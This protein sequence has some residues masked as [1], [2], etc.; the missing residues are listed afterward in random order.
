M[1]NT[2]TPVYLAQSQKMGHRTF[3]RNM[4]N[5]V[6]FFGSGEKKCT[7]MA[8]KQF[9]EVTVTF[10]YILITFECTYL[11]FVI[12]FTQAK[13]LENNISTENV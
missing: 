9:L 5:L 3:C 11:I 4:S 7:Q 2:A 1:K 8:K 6:C 10:D 13:F 12:C